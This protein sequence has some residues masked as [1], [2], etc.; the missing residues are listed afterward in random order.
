MVIE[1]KSK[2]DDTFEVEQEP[3]EA[4]DGEAQQT[5]CEIIKETIL[6]LRLFTKKEKIGRIC[7]LRRII[8][9]KFYDVSTCKAVSQFLPYFLSIANYVLYASTIRSLMYV[10]IC[11]RAN[12]AQAVGTVNMFMV[13]PGREHW[14]TIKR[15]KICCQGFD[16]DFACDLDKRKY[17]TSYVFTLVRG[18]TR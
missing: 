16:L 14:N 11:T 1:N 5:R 15:I 18:A 4:S 6:A 10:M 3:D 2:E 17:T 13:D 7:F 9:L 12:I 8:H